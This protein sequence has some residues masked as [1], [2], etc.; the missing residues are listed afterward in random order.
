[1][2]ESLCY[3]CLTCFACPLPPFS[4]SYWIASAWHFR[5]TTFLAN[6]YGDLRISMVMF[7]IHFMFMFLFFSCFVALESSIGSRTYLCALWLVYCFVV[8][9]FL[10]FRLFWDFQVKIYFD[11]IL[12]V[13]FLFFVTN[14]IYILCTCIHIYPFYIC[15]YFMNTI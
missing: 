3:I 6:V 10:I 13:E 15:E 9:T 2:W 14:I 5:V 11:L 8:V 12:Q 7:V 1:M 4:P